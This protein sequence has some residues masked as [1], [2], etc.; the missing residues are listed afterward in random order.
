ML[1][2]LY[3]KTA[4]YADYLKITEEIVA[5]DPGNPEYLYELASAYLVAGDTKKSIDVY[6]KLEDILGVNEALSVQK[7]NLFLILK[8]PEK[9]ALELE[10]LVIQ[11]PANA[12]Y[13]AML[14]EL[15]IDIGRKD[16]ALK[17]Y[18]KISSL[19]P[20]DPYVHISISDF[21]RKNGQYDLAHEEL[22]KGFAN[23]LLDID[24]KIQILLTYYTPEELFSEKTE[25]AFEL[26]S[27]L[28]IAHPYDPKAYS[29]YADLLY[30]SNDFENA[31]TA[32]LKVLA[33]DSTK[34]FVW[35]QL[36]FIDNELRNFKSMRNL[37]I[38]ALEL[39]PQQP[40]LYL[41]AA[42]SSNQLREFDNS[43]EFLITGL[44]F[45][46]DNHNLLEQ[47]YMFLGDNY[48]ELHDY[49]N[50][51]LYYDKV[52]EI[53]PENSVVLNNYAYYL[54]LRGSD[55]PKAEKMAAKAV[56][57]DPDNPANLDTYGWVLYKMGKYAEAEVLI[58]KAIT[59]DN[60]R[61][62]TLLEHYGDILF[63]LGRKKE[64]V[65]YWIKAK[66]KGKGSEFL[67][68]KIEDGI[69]YE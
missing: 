10:N 16:E 43:I 47:F 3:G 32:F 62:D 5:L 18:Q 19:F 6:N 24:S 39:F 22:V 27:K 40:L 59:I 25:E 12:K 52:L 55:L 41:F 65:D 56:G 4:L 60:E 51:Y 54:S 28:I 35:E 67:L 46:V 45:V 8:E 11:F 15:Y 49:K 21:Y 36:L 64:A 58:M 7:K 30:Q 42:I 37:S 69:L 13:Y 29:V 33:L 14:A 57:I 53:N 20:D 61:D 2:E 26:A 48:N 1:A 23:A 17:T 68:R 66:S 50:S 63:R 44:N 9:A 31:K 34:Y 38:R